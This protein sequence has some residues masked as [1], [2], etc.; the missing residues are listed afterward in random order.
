MANCT[1][2]YN[3]AFAT[4]PLKTQTGAAPPASKEES[5]H[6]QAALITALCVLIIGIAMFFVGRARGIHR[7]EPPATSGHPDFER[8]FRAHQNTLEQTAMFLPLLW[9]ATIYSNEQYA[10]YLGYAWLIGRLWYVFGY[11]AEASKRSMGFL[12]AFLATFVLLVMSLWGI[13]GRM[14]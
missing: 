10:A 11:I 3:A 8:A 14:L 12:V 13:V 5:M 7:I 9:L 2:A 4:D 6:L 1:V